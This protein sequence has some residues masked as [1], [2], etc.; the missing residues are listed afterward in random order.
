[1]AWTRQDIALQW[2][3]ATKPKE[4]GRGELS[5]LYRKQHTGQLGWA[6]LIKCPTA[7][8]TNLETDD[9]FEDYRWQFDIHQARQKWQRWVLDSA[10]II[11]G[12][13]IRL[14]GQ[15]FGLKKNEMSF[16]MLTMRSWRLEN[17]NEGSETIQQRTWFGQIRTEVFRNWY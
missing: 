2:R 12:K 1:V 14:T 11:D 4:P 7:V 15:R 9:E 6:F 3:E 17:L 8:Y 5:T 16:V 10:I 13:E